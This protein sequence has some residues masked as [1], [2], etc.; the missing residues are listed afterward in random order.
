M[1]KIKKTRISEIR[2]DL[3]KDGDYFSI[4]LPR[5]CVLFNDDFPFIVEFIEDIGDVSSITIF[6]KDYQDEFKDSRILNITVLGPKRWLHNSRVEK[7]LD[8]KYRNQATRI[9]SNNDYT[10][11]GIRW[12]K[13]AYFSYFGF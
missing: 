13:G 9:R 12:D 2:I 5:N 11:I 6:L 4:I 1:T 10:M 8:L 7:S 3:F